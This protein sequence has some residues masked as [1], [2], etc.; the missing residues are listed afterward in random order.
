MKLCSLF[1][2]ET[3]DDEGAEEAAPA[4]RVHADGGGGVSAC[5]APAAPSWEAPRREEAD[6]RRS[7]STYTPPFLKNLH[8]LQAGII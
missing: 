5:W 6:A 2:E 4:H 7:A 3:E 8:P 1:R